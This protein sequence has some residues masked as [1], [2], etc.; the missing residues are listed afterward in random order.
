[1]SCVGSVAKPS[2]S[3]ICSRDSPSVDCFGSSSPPIAAS[4]LKPMQTL[5]WAIAALTSSM[6]QL[7]EP[8]GASGF[9]WLTSTSIAF[10]PAASLMTPSIFLSPAFHRLPP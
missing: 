5:P 7:P 6:N 1:V 9:I 4:Q 2:L 8:L 10:W 3:R